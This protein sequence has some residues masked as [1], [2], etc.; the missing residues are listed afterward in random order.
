[1]KAAAMRRVFGL[2]WVGWLNRIVLRWFFVCL[3][4]RVEDDD[5]VSGY[6]LARWI[7]PFPWQTFKRIGRKP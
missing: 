4:Y 6:F 2:T 3:A 1:M 5:T 7:W